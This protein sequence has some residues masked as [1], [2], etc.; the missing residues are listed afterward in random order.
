VSYHSRS[1]ETGVWGIWQVPGVE[2]RER[3]PLD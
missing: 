2:Q 3:N 1:L